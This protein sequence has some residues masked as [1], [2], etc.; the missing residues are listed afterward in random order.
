MR[1]W[2]VCYLFFFATTSQILASDLHP[3][4]PPDRS[5]PRATL[6][7]FI[8]HM[9]AAHRAYIGGAGSGDV[10]RAFGRA[11]DCFDLRDV[12]PTLHFDVGG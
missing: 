1:A 3:L 4:A 6:Q 7:S 5:S 8:T 9:N 11:L 10:A 2:L 12:A